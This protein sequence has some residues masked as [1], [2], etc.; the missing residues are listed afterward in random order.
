MLPWNVPELRD[1]SI[2]GMNHF[3]QG[4]E[5]HL[6]VAMTRSGRCIVAEGDDEYVVF[7]WLAHQAEALKRTMERLETVPEPL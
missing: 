3:R 1:W 4:G 7:R 6:F 5:R 2:V